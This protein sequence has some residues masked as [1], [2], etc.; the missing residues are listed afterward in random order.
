MHT[1]GCD[2]HQH[3]SRADR[4]SGDHI[5]LICNANRKAG[6]I[7]FIFRIESRHLRSL[8]ADQSGAGLHAPFRNALDDLGDLIRIVLSASDIIQEEQG[9]AA[10]TCDVIH[11]HGNAVD[12]DGIMPVQKKCQFQFRTDTIR[13]GD[14]HRLFHA[15]Q[16]FSAERTGESAQSS[17]D[18]RTSCTLHELFHKSDGFI[19]CFDIYACLLVIHRIIL[20]FISYNCGILC[21]EVSGPSPGPLHSSSVNTLSASQEAQ[22]H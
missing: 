10:C 19:S 5:F 7:V 3:I 16:C 21:C 2:P 13:S 4:L 8:S 18:F 15:L 1:A 22:D 11:T 9:L 6:Q 12:P 14:K 20:P 17:Q